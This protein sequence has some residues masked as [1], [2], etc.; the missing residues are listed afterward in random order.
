MSNSKNA[1]LEIKNLM[2]KFGFYAETEVTEESFLD[3]KLKDGTE[4]KVEGENVLE[5]AKILVK[6][7]EGEIPAPDGVHELENGLKVETKD[8]I[9]AKIEK[10]VSEEEPKIEVEVE[11][12]EVELPVEG[13]PV[14]DGVDVEALYSLLKDMMEKIS[15]EMKK[16]EDK[17]E[18]FDADF[19]AFKKEPAAK[20]IATGKAEAFGK[21]S[22]I[23]DRIKAI[24]S[25]R[26]N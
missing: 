25:M 18:K 14:A 24:M 19:E 9:I 15:T 10:A 26:E 7:A 16:M 17:M 1:I 21:E 11:A 4:I 22:S 3:A 2:K 6:T 5:G 20:K 8:G 23:D 13:E 12:E